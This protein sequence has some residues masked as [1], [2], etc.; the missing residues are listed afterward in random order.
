MR[1]P[2]FDLRLPISNAECE[3]DSELFLLRWQ[4]KWRGDRERFF[5]QLCF[6]R[7]AGSG[8]M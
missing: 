8:I 3:K 5:D 1:F 6:R 4:P 7:S 2:I